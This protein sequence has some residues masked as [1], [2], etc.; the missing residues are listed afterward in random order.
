MHPKQ[1]GLHK[2]FISSCLSIFKKN[3]PW[4]VS[5]QLW[6][7]EWSIRQGY[8]QN[9]ITR[10][11]GKLGVTFPI[12]GIRH[13]KAV[14]LAQHAV[15]GNRYE[16]LPASLPDL[17][18]PVT[19]EGVK[20]LIFM[21][22]ERGYWK[23]FTAVPFYIDHKRWKTINMFVYLEGLVTSAIR[24]TAFVKLWKYSCPTNF[25]KYF[26]PSEGLLDNCH[27]IVYWFYCQDIVYYRSLTIK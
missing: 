23:S 26:T 13:L 11:V 9:F 4:E 8:F 19:E 22:G 7:E 14:H 6:Y 18:D 3:S 15:R 24:N 10:I 27:D 25:L 16:I 12:V 5:P 21:E 20:K 1:I 17:W 2:K